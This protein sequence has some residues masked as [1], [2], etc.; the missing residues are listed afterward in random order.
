MGRL[1][2]ALSFYKKYIGVRVRTPRNGLC[3]SCVCGRVAGGG[4]LPGVGCAAQ[5]CRAAPLRLGVGVFSGYAAGDGDH[6]DAF[7]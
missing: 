5:V 3:H 2:M 7:S 4:M 6:T 1:E